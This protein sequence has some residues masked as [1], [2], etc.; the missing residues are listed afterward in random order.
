MESAKEHEEGPDEFQTENAC[1]CHEGKTYVVRWNNKVDN[2]ERIEVDDNLVPL[3][4]KPLATACLGEAKEGYHNN[5][6]IAHLPVEMQ[7]PDGWKGKVPNFTNQMY[8][9]R[10]KNVK[11]KR[12]VGALWESFNLKTHNV[13]TITQ[14]R[15]RTVLLLSMKEQGKQKAQVCV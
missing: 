12:N 6:K 7:W 9:D 15:D 5:P 2:A 8:Y 1:K 10:M 4:N 3:K 14:R 13:I 11:Q